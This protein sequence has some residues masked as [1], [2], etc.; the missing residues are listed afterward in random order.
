M[1]YLDKNGMPVNQDGSEPDWNIWTPQETT[2]SF[3]D[4]G[5]PFVIVHCKKMTQREKETNL[6][7]FYQL[8]LD[9][10]Q[11]DMLRIFESFLTGEP[12]SDEEA[13]R[14]AQIV[15]RRKLWRG[16]IDGIMNGGG[17]NGSQE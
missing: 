6:L 7:P 9:E 17:S 5:N 15:E 13:E 2:Q 4:A 16:K 12:L 11:N 14:Y 1:I 8:K 10:T 3:D